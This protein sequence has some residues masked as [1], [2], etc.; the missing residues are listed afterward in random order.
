MIAGGLTFAIPGVMPS[1]SAVTANLY[2]SAE[3]SMFDNSFAGP[4]VIEVVVNDPDL[5]N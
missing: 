2:V 3:N 4:M 1:A 5:K